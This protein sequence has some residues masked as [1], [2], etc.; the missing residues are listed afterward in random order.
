MSKPSYEQLKEKI[1]LLEKELAAIRSS[2]RDEA[3]LPGLRAMI[4]FAYDWEYWRLPDGTIRYTS[5]SCERITGYRPDEFDS[6]PRL[7]LSIV[8]PDD[9]CFVE[10]HFRC[11][12][13]RRADDVLVDFRIIRRDG[14][15]KWIAHVCSPMLDGSGRFLGRRVSHRDITDRK[16]MEMALQTSE[17]K[18]R[19]L[20]ENS[21]AG[22]GVSQGDRIIYANKALLNMYGYSSFEE[23]SSMSIL[24][25]STEES[26]E[27][28]RGWRRRKANG[29]SIPMEFN[30]Q[31][32]C[33]NGTARTLRLNIN[34]VTIDGLQYAYTTFVDVTDLLAAYQAKRES[35]EFL[36][37]L[38]NSIPGVVYQFY[39][40][41]N[42][43]MGFYYISER[44]ADFLGQEKV[45]DDVFELFIA[46]MTPEDRGRFLD[47]IR[48]AVR[49]N[50]T[51]QFEGRFIAR[52]GK[53]RYFSGISH[54][55]RSGGEVVFNGLMLDNTERKRAEERLKWQLA[56]NMAL[57]GLSGSIIAQSFTI[58]DIAAIALQYA[59]LLTDSEH[60]FVS[61]IDPQTRKNVIHAMDGAL[62]SAVDREW[63]PAGPDNRYAGI[64]GKVLNEGRAFFTNDPRSHEAWSESREGETEIRRYL[65]VPVLLNKDV[66]GEVVLT[67]ADRDYTGEDLV[68]TR[69][70]ASLYAMAI[71]RIRNEEDL[72]ESLHEKE[73]LIKELHHRVKNNLQVVSSLLALQSN[74]I[75]S[76]VYRGYFQESQNRV[77]A[78]ALIHEKLYNS[79]AL[80]RIDFS[81]YI[82][83]LTRH[84]FYSYNINTQKVRLVI[85]VRDVYLGIDAAVPCAM[86]INELV[87]N[88][89]KHGFPGDRAG[90]IVVGLAKN[91]GDGYTLTVSDN[92]VGMPERVEGKESASLGM[93][94]VASL[95]RQIKGAIDVSGQGGT[96]VTITF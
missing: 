74:R 55:R 3:G 57:A 62:F 5:P 10:E 84:L 40:R 22:I 43:E 87:S 2:H 75:D 66:V 27:F 41:D 45:T 60:G 77:H 30:H 1:A 50:K 64:W 14:Q 95:T 42:G 86:I 67:N 23:L 94:I 79:E 18:Y 47:S 34:Y 16:N 53:I 73:I 54:P 32:I 68:T 81:R 28:L 93:Q 89:L 56:M 25:H 11:A 71:A 44:A 37:S 96:R 82:D 17:E 91:A 35:E 49:Q 4:D 88:S 80:A 63:N 31:I 8:H 29:E 76:E 19:A 52:N 36:R 85:D 9:R 33:K 69:R 48:E 83:D 61:E 65:G 24:D 58:K 7:I 72:R 70:I 6:D 13:N 92:G 20:L 21:L 15:V 12:E 59:R 46:G 39:V 26:R 38:A 78:M 90:E 51:W